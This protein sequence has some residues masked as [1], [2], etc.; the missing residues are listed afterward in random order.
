MH[1][2]VSGVRHKRVQFNSSL[3]R[4]RKHSLWFDTFIVMPV[5][6]ADS[7][8]LLELVGLS[9]NAPLSSKQSTPHQLI[10]VATFL[11]QWLQKSAHM[12]KL[13][14]LSELLYNR[15]AQLFLFA[16]LRLNAHDYAFVLQ[17]KTALCLLFVLIILS[18][19]SVKLGSPLS[20][21]EQATRASTFAT[22]RK[23]SVGMT[24]A[25][26]DVCVCC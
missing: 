22:P 9:V 24:P 25:K 21:L 5:T 1:V 26:R 20:T 6:R 11:Y 16:C 15:C 17:A 19:L 10:S 7:T 8:A 2:H 12:T 3:F 18:F 13:P 14:L 23:P 4:R